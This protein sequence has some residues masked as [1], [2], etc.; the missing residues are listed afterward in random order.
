MS[1]II[2]VIVGSLIVGFN[3]CVILLRLLLYACILDTVLAEAAA[4]DE[5][6]S[7]VKFCSS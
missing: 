1:F 7:V 5:K 2:A 6:R 4:E 3:G